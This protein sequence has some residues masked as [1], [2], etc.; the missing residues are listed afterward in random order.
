MFLTDQTCL[1][2]SDGNMKMFFF[3]SDSRYLN[4]LLSQQLIKMQTQ[5]YKKVSGVQGLPN[6]CRI[7]SEWNKNTIWEQT[8]RIVKKKRRLTRLWV[9]LAL[10]FSSPRWRL[11][12]WIRWK[13]AVGKHELR[14]P[15]CAKHSKNTCSCFLQP[16]A[17]RPTHWRSTFVLSNSSKDKNWSLTGSSTSPFSFFLTFLLF[18]H[19]SVCLH[20]CI[21][22]VTHV[23]LSWSFIFEHL[24]F[25]FF[26]LSSNLCPQNL[27]NLSFIVICLHYRFLSSQKQFQLSLGMFGSF[28]LNFL[29]Y[30]NDYQRFQ[31]AFF[32]LLL[33]YDYN[34]EKF[35]NEF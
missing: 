7:P 16:C 3:R 24:S 32:C 5:R 1:C 10:C 31:T 14:V 20:H 33:S 30:V 27:L 4:G 22:P 18:S 21:I 15:A 25:C 12:L 11:S 28:Q 34:K 9:P 17:P 13:E 35:R 2:T 6:S 29:V 19:S 8:R 23:I 26:Q